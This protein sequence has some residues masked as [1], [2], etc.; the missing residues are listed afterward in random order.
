MHSEAPS[1]LYLPAS[2]LPEHNKDGRPVAP[3][4]L[5]P[6]Q[7]KHD[8][9]AVAPAVALYLPMPHAVQ[10]DAAV[11]PVV[12]RYVPAAQLAQLW[13]LPVL[14]VPAAQV[15]EH[16]DVLSPGS[17]PNL[18]LAQPMHDPA[19]VAA[20]SVPYVPAPHEM[21]SVDEALPVTE[22]YLPAGQSMQ[23]V[24]AGSLP[25][26][27]P[28]PHTWN[29]RGPPPSST[30]P[31]PDP[32]ARTHMGTHSGS[33]SGV[34]SCREQLAESGIRSEHMPRQCRSGQKEGLGRARAQKVKQA[35]WQAACAARLCRCRCL[36]PPPYYTPHSHQHT[37]PPCTRLDSVHSST[38]SRIAQNQCR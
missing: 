16:D 27:V 35:G 28:A 6:A 37:R 4:Y 34:R 36:E 9:A 20:A 25:L 15:P 10:A 29:G 11:P 12:L 33:D 5:P 3:P 2:Q 19:E 32:H 7:S 24:L 18:P 30:P 38:P 17:E 26:Y 21:Q 22:L 23:L 1:S 8:D 31:A 13:A 14:Y